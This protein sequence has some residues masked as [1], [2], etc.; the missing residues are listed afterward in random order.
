M[1]DDLYSG[2]KC[3]F[4]LSSQ[5]CAICISYTMYKENQHM[6]CVY[7]YMY[8]QMHMYVYIYICIGERENIQA[9]FMTSVWDERG[10]WKR[11]VNKPNLDS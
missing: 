4:M 6:W 11:P 10:K 5:H 8:V 2:S 9:H 1:N 3:D 7:M